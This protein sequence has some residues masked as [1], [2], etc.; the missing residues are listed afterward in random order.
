M[1]RGLKP[2]KYKRWTELDEIELIRL[3]EEEVEL[4]D[5][6]LGQKWKA[7]KLQSEKDKHQKELDDMIQILYNEGRGPNFIE[8]MKTQAKV[9][10]DEMYGE[11]GVREENTGIGDGTGDC[12]G[13]SYQP[14]CGSDAFQLILKR[15]LYHHL[16]RSEHP[17]YIVIGVTRTLT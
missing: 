17:Q 16:R 10:L 14:F 11:F 8:G 4:K 15:I 12:T 5:T 3:Q 13:D 1:E 2:K 7:E 6:A 9:A